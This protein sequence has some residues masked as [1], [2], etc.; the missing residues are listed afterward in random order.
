MLAQ[1]QSY[2]LFRHICWGSLL[3]HDPSQTWI[4]A[5]TEHS[6]YLDAA[7]H[8]SDQDYLVVAGFLASEQ[9][10]LTFER[11][12]KECL[13]TNG[14]ADPFHANKFFHEY[15]NSPLKYPILQELVNVIV[16]NV[17]CAFSS[18]IDLIQ[19]RRI[20]ERYRFEEIVGTPYAMSARTVIYNLGEWRKLSRCDDPVL[21]FVE[22]GTLHE[23]DMRECLRDRDKLPEPIPVPKAMPAC[24][25]ADLY[26]YG[27]F[28]YAQS[29]IRQ[30]VLTMFHEKL[31]FPLGHYDGFSG[32]KDFR[33]Y[34]S[35]PRA[36]I[37]SPQFP[38]GVKVPI[39][40]RKNTEG[41]TFNFAATPKKPRI[42]RVK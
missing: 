9:Q 24:Q 11:E 7:G 23:G 29:R 30:R 28:H 5:M 14:V 18:T 15:A 42:R 32:K 38:Q 20:N 12:W 37:H 33:A 31:S 17:R 13:G 41:L 40:L 1:N 36:V 27:V 6:L 39:P 21:F 25:A 2:S 3:S 19:Y 8:P 4:A 35:E 16:R 26:A 22:S 34:L 10:W